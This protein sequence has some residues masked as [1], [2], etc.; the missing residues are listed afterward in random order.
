M[1]A[2][3]ASLY[4]T[5]IFFEGDSESYPK[6]FDGLALRLTGDQLVPMGSTASGDT[7]TLAKLDLLIDSVQGGPDVLFMNKTMRRKVNSLMRSAGQATEVVSDAFGRQINAYAGVPIGIIEDD[8]SGDAILDFDE[9]CPGGG[10]DLGTSIYAV[11]FGAGEYV[12]G[13]QAGTMDVIDLGLYSGG[14]A[15]RTLIEWI[16]GMAVFH[17]K[18]AA[19]LYGIKNA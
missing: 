6:Q 14:V 15:Y 2:K 19:R 9:A 18:S 17:P 16:C 11:R 10:S 5:K 1:K 3:A 13:L 8:E 7:L 4:F 12:S